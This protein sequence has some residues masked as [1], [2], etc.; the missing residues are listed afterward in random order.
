[1]DLSF[2]L[3]GIPGSV[4]VTYLPDEAPALMGAPASSVGFPTCHASVAYPAQGYDAVLGWV[5]LVRSDDNV[6]EG[7][8]FE[9]DPL[10]FLGDVPH[11]FCWIGLEPQLFDAPSRSPRRDMDWA[12]HS[13]LCVPDGDDDGMVAH[14][15]VGFLWGFRI[16]DEE[17]HLVPP[18]LLRPD[19]W[20]GHRAALAARY[21]AWRFAPGFRA[22][23][24]ATT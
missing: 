20:D 5:Q 18:T 4:V 3:R 19:D 23:A 2:V 21:P 12:A 9:I 17:I 7:R 6:S 24:S 11:P 1:M 16:R 13:F 15:L 10:D 22:D 14:A 8:E